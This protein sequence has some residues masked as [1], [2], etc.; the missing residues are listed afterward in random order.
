ML[1]DFALVP[2]A[3][4]RGKN[5]TWAGGQSERA[6]IDQS[7]LVL[8]LGISLGE[9]FLLHNCTMDDRVKR[10]YFGAFGHSDGEVG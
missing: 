2:I 7:Q 4:D 8:T 3:K 5:T 6:H 1:Y 9:S 10:D